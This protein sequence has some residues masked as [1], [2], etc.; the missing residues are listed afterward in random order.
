MHKKLSLVFTRV[1]QRDA[2]FYKCVA[3]NAKMMT[4]D[5]EVELIVVGNKFCF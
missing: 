1:A 3:R 4:A 5:W 2:G